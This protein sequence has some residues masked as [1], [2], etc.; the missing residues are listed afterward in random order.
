MRQASAAARARSVSDIS[1]SW[2]PSAAALP[3]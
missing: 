2:A 3:T 1:A